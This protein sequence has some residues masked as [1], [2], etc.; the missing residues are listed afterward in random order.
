[1]LSVDR[2]AGRLSLGL[3]PSYLEGESDVEEDKDGIED[4]DFD[5]ELQGAME[6]GLEGGSVKDEDDV[7]EEDEPD[8]E[9]DL[10]EELMG[11]EASE[12]E[13]EEEEDS[14]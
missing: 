11:A 12:G 5:E 10:D 8:S 4:M 9:F 3:K 14:D 13:E 7:E 6:V 2:K 1:M